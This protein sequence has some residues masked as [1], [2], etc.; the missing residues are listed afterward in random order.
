MKRLY[1]L[2]FYFI[3]AIGFVFLFNYICPLCE[4]KGDLYALFFIVA[5]LLIEG[6]IAVWHFARRRKG[7]GSHE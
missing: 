3:V 2:V 6:S 1:R 7:N 5:V 4:I